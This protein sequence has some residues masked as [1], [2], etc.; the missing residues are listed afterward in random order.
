MCAGPF[1]SNTIWFGALSDTVNTASRMES[2]GLPDKIQTSEQTASLLK[3][4]GKD[5]WIRRQK[6]VF[7]SY[8]DWLKLKNKVCNGKPSWE[9]MSVNIFLTLIELPE[10]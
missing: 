2:T 8:Y 4:A 9:V 5:E 3:A 6:L 7:E 10:Y 1:P